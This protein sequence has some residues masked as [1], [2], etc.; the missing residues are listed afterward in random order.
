MNSLLI[1][2]RREHAPTDHRAQRMW[3]KFS[4]QDP[5]RLVARLRWPAAQTLSSAYVLHP[6]EVYTHFH[7]YSD[8][9]QQ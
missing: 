9:P 1:A 6:S 4:V 3:K 2:G 5:Q 8:I 7:T